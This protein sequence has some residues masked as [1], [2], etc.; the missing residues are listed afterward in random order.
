MRKYGSTI[1]SNDSNATP[2][3]QLQDH[4]TRLRGELVALKVE[5]SHLG[6]EAV[7]AFPELSSSRS[8]PPEIKSSCG[9]DADTL[10]TIVLVQPLATASLASLDK[11]DGDSKR[12]PI[13]QQ[14]A[15]V[16]SAD[17]ARLM[18]INNS[19]HALH[20]NGSAVAPAARYRHSEV[21]PCP[22]GLSASSTTVSSPHPRILL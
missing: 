17:Q 6:P 21:I 7:L 8:P 13:M 9:P 15:A 4:I 1:Q 22:S 19:S 18:S 3:T 5:R 2:R 14:Q 16:G 11:G 20:A 10:S 12:A